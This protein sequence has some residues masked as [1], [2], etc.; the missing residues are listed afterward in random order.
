MCV[1]RCAERQLRQQ[2][3]APAALAHHAPLTLIRFKTRVRRKE[4]KKKQKNARKTTAAGVGGCELEGVMT[5]RRDGT[6][7]ACADTNNAVNQRAYSWKI[8]V[9]RQ[10]RHGMR[11]HF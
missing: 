10:Q 4:I 1:A 9:D 8:R 6:I 11:A 5:H 3:D 7:L 2:V